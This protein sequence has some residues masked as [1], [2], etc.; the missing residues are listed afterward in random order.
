MFNISLL[1]KY[2]DIMAPYDSDGQGIT[3]ASQASVAASHIAVR[4]LN[5]YAPI[6]QDDCQPCGDWLYQNIDGADAV[7]DKMLDEGRKPEVDG[8]KYETLLEELLDIVANE[9]L[10][11]ELNSYPAQGS[12]FNCQGPIFAEIQKYF[13]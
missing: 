6:W 3:M 5:E 8:N 2:L 4:Y 12:I 10:L 1:N 9:D 11:I 13:D 7:I